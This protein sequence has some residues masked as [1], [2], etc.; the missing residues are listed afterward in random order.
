MKK[1]IIILSVFSVF[2]FKG[3]AQGELAIN[4][5]PYMGVHNSFSQPGYL[6]YSPYKLDAN[7]IG[8]KA[9]M[10]NQS[11]MPGNRSSV[12]DVLAGE[13]KLRDLFAVGGR[14][15]FVSASIVL[16]S[17]LYSI[18]EKNVISFTSRIRAVGHASLR[19]FNAMDFF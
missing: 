4:A 17:A 2:C 14:D 8:L 18:D 15:V 6:V 9:S 5:L 10:F 13:A 1:V 16:P 7:I 11:F 19:E 3:I 12:D